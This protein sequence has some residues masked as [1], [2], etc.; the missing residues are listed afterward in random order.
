MVLTMT[1][2]CDL[3][4]CDYQ[5]RCETRLQG[6]V[7]EFF[8]YATFVSKVPAAFLVHV[9]RILQKGTDA[10]WLTLRQLML[11]VIAQLT[12]FRQAIDDLKNCYE[13]FFNIKKYSNPVLKSNLQKLIDNFPNMGAKLSSVPDH[14]YTYI[15]TLEEFLI[16]AP[17]KADK[18]LSVDK[19]K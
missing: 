1:N 18:I 3:F 19:L 5:R 11:E 7:D 17:P 14:L 15:T 16:P 4:D 9:N 12:E 10:D 2:N 8:S 13:C 6:Y